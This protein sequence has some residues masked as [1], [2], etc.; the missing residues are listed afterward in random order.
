MGLFA[1]LLKTYDKCASAVGIIPLDKGN[2]DEK[3]A[4]LPIFHT[5]L[6]SEVCFVLDEKGTLLSCFRDGKE[7][8]IIIPCTEESASRSS[9]IAAHP[10]C[11]SISYIDKN[12]NKERY[13]AYLE[14]LAA[15]KGNNTKLNAIY[16]FLGENSVV[17]LMNG[18]GLFKDNEY[19]E[20]ALNI[21]KISKIGIRFSVEIP[22]NTTPNV[23]EDSTLQEEWI[24]HM[25]Q[26]DAT[27]NT[28][29][30]DYLSGDNL[31]QKARTHPKNINAMTG[32]AKLL[33]CN[34]TSGLTFRGRF[35]SQDDA[36]MVD[37]LSSQK[38]HQTLR[39]L[40]ANYSSKT[41]SQA[42]VIWAIDDVPEEK[43]LPFG[44]SFDIFS[45]LANN[46]EVMS[47]ND[48]MRAAVLAIDGDY[49]KKV[50]KEL[51][52]FGTA[53]TIKNHDRTV[54]IAIFDAATTGRMSVTF[55]QEMLENEYLENIA[56][57]HETS[58]WLLTTFRKEIKGKTQEKSIPF[59]YV[60]C[61][62][63]EEIL[64]TV[65]GKPRGNSDKS[66]GTL[67]KN[68]RKQL[69]ECM[70]GNF[71]FP[72]NYID[73]ATDRVSQPMS[74]VDNDGQFDL[75]NWRR[76]LKIACSLIKKYLLQQFKEDISM[77]L[78]VTRNDRDYLYGRLLAIA[79]R[80]ESTAMYK[81]D[82]TDTRATNAVKL[83]SSFAVKP[84]STWGVIW[85]QLIPYKNQ[86]KG[87][88]Y[89]QKLIDE[90]MVLFK[91][92]EFESNKPLSPLYLL[93]YSAQNMVL[94][95]KNKIEETEE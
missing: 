76:A 24:S 9:G 94:T 77:E 48:K 34:D 53:E 4:F 82:I 46:E 57:W 1:N 12:I 33:S 31:F 43:I 32:N 47:D 38:L 69:L 44:S 74:F 56:K 67:E 86:L 58:A 83:M 72:K 13:T 65:Y 80:L 7:Q 89:Y 15:R 6:K 3:R 23:W 66:Y 84:F 52:G 10:L 35:E 51:R 45:A 78:Q 64:E 91:D 92:K 54:A 41:E 73:M 14:Q 70:F 25:S 28:G 19:T 95:N 60:G 61:P 26:Y 40:I 16:A 21:D 71:A 37:M 18:A 22:G 93:G 79:D 68:I 36:I 20:G 90:I 11:D 85:N 88:G 55:Y 49:A 63:F 30:F 8:T 62:S 17:E 39:W 29:E 59:D 5:T 87:A 42:I 27:E 50:A 81:A 75:F 2:A